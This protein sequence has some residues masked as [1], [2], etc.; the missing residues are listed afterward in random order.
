M[1]KIVLAITLL[2][3]TAFV[4]A[5]DSIVVKP[6]DSLNA[7]EKLSYTMKHHNIF[8][9]LD[10]SLTL[11]TTGVG[12]D[13]ASPIGDYV[14][15]RAGYAFMPHFNYN[16]NF[17]VQ[18][19]D[20][21]EVN[22][23]EKGN[24]LDTR[25]NRLADMM[26]KMTG[27]RVDDN[28]DMIGEPSYHNFKLMV[29]V[30]PFKNNKHWHFT[31]GFYLGPSQFA[32]A[33]NTTEDAPSLL[34]VNIYNQMYEKAINEE[35]M[36]ELQINGTWVAF[37]TD[38][39]AYLRKIADLFRSYGRMGYPMGQF[40]HDIYDTAGNLIHKE[41]DTYMMEP[42]S[43]GMAKAWMK[44]N[45]FKPY[46]GFGYGGRLFKGND[47]YKIS[48]DC[49]AMF[50]GGTPTIVTHDGIDLAKDIRNIGGKVGRYVDLA[51]TFKVFP[52]LN[53]RITRTLF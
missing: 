38:D 43:D 12:I 5:Q 40:S 33:Y 23:D 29:D 1:K 26:E 15:L 2:M 50:W 42:G 17:G 18:V 46:L 20:T 7:M 16:M 3:Q 35:P 44:T 48:F 49:G 28:V 37:P 10:L 39:P 52:V 4:A 34:A 27:I 21:K 36:M 45:G 25:F 11:G 14:Q 31:V 32:K 24:R 30:Y 19:G 22:Y 6:W 9:H 8:Q 13:V 41:G 51:T 47:K 53:V